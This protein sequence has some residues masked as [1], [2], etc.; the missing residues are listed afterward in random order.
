MSVAENYRD[1]EEP[2]DRLSSREIVNQ[3][4][5]LDGTSSNPEQARNKQESMSPRELATYLRGKSTA[6]IFEAYRT[7]EGGKVNILPDLL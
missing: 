1:D 4:L 5:I 2:G 6:E 3:L 7:K